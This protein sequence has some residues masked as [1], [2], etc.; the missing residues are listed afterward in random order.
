MQVTRSGSTLVFTDASE[1]EQKRLL[2]AT[3]QTPATIATYSRKEAAKIF[4]V[5]PG[6]L[7]RW[8]KSGKLLAIRVTARTL[9]YDARQIEAIVSGVAK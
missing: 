8:E 6:S 1:E 7:K 5:H 3:K 4:G 2:A 9:R